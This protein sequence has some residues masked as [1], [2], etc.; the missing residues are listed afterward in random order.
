MQGLPLSFPIGVFHREVWRNFNEMQ[1]RF[2]G[3]A[4]PSGWPVVYRSILD[5]DH[6]A[7]ELT[8]AAANWN[9]SH[10]AAETF[11]IL[12]LTT[13]VASSS[14]SRQKLCARARLAIQGLW[15]S[16]AYHL[17]LITIPSHLSAGNSYTHVYTQS[18]GYHILIVKDWTWVDCAFLNNI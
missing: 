8:L 10:M 1:M 13:T 2:S 3:S 11:A 17:H 15:L 5:S 12:H 4:P 16:A 7:I 9:N 14:R 6:F 18:L